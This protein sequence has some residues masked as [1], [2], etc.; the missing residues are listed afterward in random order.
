MSVLQKCF[1]ECSCLFFFFF[2]RTFFRTSNALFNMFTQNPFYCFPYRFAVVAHRVHFC[3][4]KH[5]CFQ[6]SFSF[7]KGAGSTGATVL[8]RSGNQINQKRFLKRQIIMVLGK[9]KP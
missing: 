2:E 7:R 5:N 4:E 1:W 8:E 9:Q 3:L 6:S